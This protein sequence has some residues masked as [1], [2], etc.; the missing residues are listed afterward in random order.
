MTYH[1]KR[2]EEALPT[3]ELLA[4]YRKHIEAKNRPAGN[5]YT[6]IQ[7]KLAEF[8]KGQRSRHPWK[9]AV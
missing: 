6:S 3:A 4:K 7:M 5:S 8:R 1:E 9:G 2:R